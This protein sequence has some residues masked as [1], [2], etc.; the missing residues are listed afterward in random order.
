MTGVFAAAATLIVSVTG[1]LAPALLLATSCTCTEPGSVGVPLRAPLVVLSATPIWPFTN[2]ELVMTGEFGFATMRMTSD[3]EAEPVTLV[4]VSVTG[5]VPACEGVPEMTPLANV[6]PGGQRAREGVGRGVRSDGRVG[7]A[8][9]GDGA[10]DGG[11]AREDRRRRVQREDDRLAIGA[12]G[13]GVG[14]REH[15]IVG[16]GG[17]GEDSAQG[18]GGWIDS[19]SRE[20]GGCGGDGERRGRR[21]GIEGDR[22]E[23]KI[24]PDDDR[25]RECGMRGDDGRHRV[26][27]ERPRDVGCREIVGVARLPRGDRA[28]A[29]ADDGDGVAAHGGDGGIRAR[30]GDGETGIGGGTES[31]WRR[32]DHFYRQRGEV[33]RLRRFRDDE[34]V[35]GGSGVIRVGDGRGDLVAAG[36]RRRGRAAGSVVEIHGQAGGGRGRGERD[37][38]CAVV[39]GGEVAERDRG[40]GLRD[41]ER[42]GTLGAAAK[43]T[44]PGWLAVMRASPAPT[45]VTMTPLIVATLV[46]PLV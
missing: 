16:A 30:V 37:L 7:E 5:K 10:R 32:R 11:H 44:L 29:E 1:K 39:G 8:A 33:D 34:R 24:T 22:T 40:S 3:S 43:F 41:G 28:R 4:A 38:R 20:A 18:A 2:A 6:R 36:I 35:A 9:G 21:A 13:V 27:D 26:D 46:F 15:N 17:A 19:E 14:H 31:E 45:M 25:V 12:G 23:G 42:A